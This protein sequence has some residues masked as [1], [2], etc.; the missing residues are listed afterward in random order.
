VSIHDLAKSM[1]FWVFIFYW[2]KMYGR[3]V[4]V[5]VHQY[6][7]KTSYACAAPRWVAMLTS[8]VLAYSSLTPV[9]CTCLT[10]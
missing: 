7:Q 9:T 10:A 8:S 5:A 6:T 1:A 2:H 4:S 3:W